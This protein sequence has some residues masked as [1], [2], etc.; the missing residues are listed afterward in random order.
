M[1]TAS[2]IAAGLIIGALFLFA[3]RLLGRGPETIALGAKLFIPLRSFMEKLPIFRVIFGVPAA[4][5]G[6]LWWK[7]A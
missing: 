2:I 5:A 6:L 1:R 7:Y 3:G 4:A